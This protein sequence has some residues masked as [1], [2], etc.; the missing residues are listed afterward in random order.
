MQ[1]EEL[2][3]L[4]FLL[5]GFGGAVHGQEN[6]GD[7]HHHGQIVEH[8]GA[9]LFLFRRQAV[10]V[11]RRDHQLGH[12]Q[13]LVN[14]LDHDLLVDALVL[15]AD[16]VAVE[17]E[18]HIIQLFAVR[19]RQINKDVIH[20]ERV[21]G[22]AQAAGAQDL[23][24]V[25]DAVHQDVLAGRKAADVRPGKQAVGGQHAG[26]A[27]RVAGVVHRMLIDIIAQQ[28][29][30]RLRHGGKLAQFFHDT[31]KRFAVEP[32]VRIDDLEVKPLRV[33]DALVDALA[34]AAVLLVDHADDVGIFFGPGVGN[35]AGLV[36]GTIVHQDDLGFGPGGQQRFDAAVHIGRRVIAGHGECDQFH[37]C[38][39]L[40]FASMA[41]RRAAAGRA[42]P[43]GAVPCHLAGCA[44]L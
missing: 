25:D 24:A 6:A 22:Q 43:P 4:L 13:L 31:G 20:I 14:T 34:M 2:P 18:V 5:Q 35:G 30:D 39:S 9:Q 33:A 27:H 11:D 8:I 36:L 1:L 10:E 7:R 15:S 28:Q 42:A 3:E 40:L 44:L 38:A 17:V 26:V 23:G 19:Q 12:A 29:V 32:V 37:G 41:A 21:L 16:E